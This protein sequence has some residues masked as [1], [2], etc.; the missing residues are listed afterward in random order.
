MI[1][2]ASSVFSAA[3][4]STSPCR[5]CLHKSLAAISATSGSWLFIPAMSALI[6]SLIGFWFACIWIIYKRFLKIIL[7]AYYSTLK[8][9][10]L[11]NEGNGFRNFR[12]ISG[13]SFEV[14]YWCS[15][16]YWAFGRLLYLFRLS[17][18][19]KFCLQLLLYLGVLDD[20]QKDEDGM[21]AADCVFGRVYVFLELFEV[22]VLNGD[23]ALP[24]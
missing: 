6:T 17:I 24:I 22:M 11:E 7:K 1:F 10:F 23:H 5:I 4:R 12:L 15:I 3:L 2:L 19:Y 13:L 9:Q 8:I 21:S 14:S 20:F 18:L 16:A